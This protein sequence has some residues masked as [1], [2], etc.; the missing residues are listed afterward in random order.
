MRCEA[1]GALLA[2]I[3]DNG[4]DFLRGGLEVTIVGDLQA[5]IIC[6]RPWCRTRNVLNLK[7]ERGPPKEAT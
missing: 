3:D 5:T 2:T 7:T 1:C 6:Y 4:L